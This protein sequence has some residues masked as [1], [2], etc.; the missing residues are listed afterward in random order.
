LS[1][2]TNLTVTLYMLESYLN[3]ESLHVLVSSKLSI[4]IWEAELFIDKFFVR[5]R[6]K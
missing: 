2:N 4:H 5:G 3:V 1:R 6:D